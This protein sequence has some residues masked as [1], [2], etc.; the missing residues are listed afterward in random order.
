[1]VRE[2]RQLLKALPI[3]GYHQYD[4]GCIALGI[5]AQAEQTA[6]YLRGYRDAHEAGSPLSDVANLAAQFFMHHDRYGRGSVIG[7]RPDVFVVG[8]DRDWFDIAV[9]VDGSY[10]DRQ[11][12][13]SVCEYLAG[14]L[15][16]LVIAMRLVEHQTAGQ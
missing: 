16:Q 7:G 8:N 1:M 13:E 2:F 5:A 3:R 10:A 12:A 14:Q 4:I 15:E 9:R 11:M 6:D